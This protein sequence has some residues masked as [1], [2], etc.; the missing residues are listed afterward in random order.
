[1]E[2]DD[3]SNFIEGDSFEYPQF[4]IRTEKWKWKRKAED[5]KDVNKE[6]N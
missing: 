2:Q 1:M 3:C 6:I 4:E 5:E